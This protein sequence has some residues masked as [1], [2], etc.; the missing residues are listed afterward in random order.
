MTTERERL[1]EIV[2]M[3]AA[4]RDVCETATTHLLVTALRERLAVFGIARTADLAVGLMAAAML[5]AEH[6]PEWGGDCRDGLAEVAQLGLA[7]L[8]DG[9]DPGDP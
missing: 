7:L 6:A 8:A 2:R 4:T 5:L 9:S 3:Q 1:M